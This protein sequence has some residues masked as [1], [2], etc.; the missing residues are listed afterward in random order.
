L[1]FFKN[2]SIII[3]V[4]PLINTLHTE[5]RREKSNAKARKKQ[6][7]TF[8][9]GWVRLYGRYLLL[10]GE[11]GKFQIYFRKIPL[12]PTKIFGGFGSF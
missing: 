10:K 1:H 3:F 11:L 2:K 6:K 8:V 9:M 7:Q 5:L 4:H 12:H